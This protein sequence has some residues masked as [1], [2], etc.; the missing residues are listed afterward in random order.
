MTK[1]EAYLILHLVG[2]FLLVAAAGL[3]TAAGTK[4]GRVTDPRTTESLLALSARG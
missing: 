1:F 3:S 2:A 4:V